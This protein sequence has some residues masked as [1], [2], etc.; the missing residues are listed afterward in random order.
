MAPMEQTNERWSVLR[1]AKEIYVGFSADRL[2]VAFI[3]PLFFANHLNDGDVVIL[4][5]AL[6]TFPIA[7]IAAMLLLKVE[8][9]KR[10]RMGA[11]LWP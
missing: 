11:G 10:S 5:A 1:T 4:V 6:V 2:A 8:A 9:V 7:L 3:S